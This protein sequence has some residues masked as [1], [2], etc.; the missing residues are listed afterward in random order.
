MPKRLLDSTLL[1]AHFQRFSPLAQK[2]PEDARNWANRLIDNKGTNAIV[3]PVVIELLAGVR[4]SHELAL[5]EAFLEKFEVVD[6]RRIPPQDWEQAGIFAKRVVKYDREVPRGSRRRDREQNPK[7]RARDLGDCLIM[8]IALRLNYVVLSHD[9]GI[10][11]QAG[12]VGGK[13]PGS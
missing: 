8:A 13:A 2:G 1:I 6:E 12:R 5:T 9:R 4:D 10:P 11:R 7:T 3:S